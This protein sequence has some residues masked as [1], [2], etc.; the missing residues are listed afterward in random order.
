MDDARRVDV[1]VL[2]DEGTAERY[3]ETVAEIIH[4]FG[5]DARRVRPVFCPA[6]RTHFTTW[7]PPRLPVAPT[8][9]HYACAR[10]GGDGTPCTLDAPR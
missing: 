9:V 10:C 4:I 3:T 2:Y 1:A 5:R 6:C 8:V 7:I